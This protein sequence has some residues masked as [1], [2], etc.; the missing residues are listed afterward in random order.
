MKKADH[1]KIY[2]IHIYKK[3]SKYISDE[4]NI[5]SDESDENIFNI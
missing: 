3:I 2:Y 1:Y 5:S 4:L